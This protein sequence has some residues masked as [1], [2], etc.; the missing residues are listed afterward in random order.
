MDSVSV[1]GDLWDGKGRAPLAV[2]TMGEG[3]RSFGHGAQKRF[4][5][6]FESGKCLERGSERTFINSRIRARDGAPAAMM[7]LT[8][9]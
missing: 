7:A 4:R 8:E 6:P 1:C 2:V 5:R 9:L 3:A